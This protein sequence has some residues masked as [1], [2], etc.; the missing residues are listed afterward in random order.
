MQIIAP[1][2]E[3]AEDIEDIKDILADLIDDI[4]AQLEEVSNPAT[5]RGGGT[6]NITLSF[7]SG[8]LAVVP[9][10]TRGVLFRISAVQAA[11]IPGFAGGYGGRVVVIQNVSAAS[12]T[13]AH[14]STTALDVERVTTRTGSALTLA[15]GAGVVLTY[16]DA[17]SR[18]IPVC[19][20]L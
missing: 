1:N 19:T 9:A 2:L 3:F 6:A 18:W 15:S 11:T 10:L 5:G 17:T 13:I 20:Q 7:S 8:E 12:Y 14:E 4:N 16:D